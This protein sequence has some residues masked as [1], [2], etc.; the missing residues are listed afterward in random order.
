MTQTSSS[1]TIL[2]PSSTSLRNQSHIGMNVTLHL[3]ALTFP[4]CALGKLGAFSIQFLEKKLCQFSMADHCL[5]P[6]AE[7]S[8]AN[9]H[10]EVVK[11]RVGEILTVGSNL[12]TLP[13]NQ[14]RVLWFP[15]LTAH[16]S[17]SSRLHVSSLGHSFSHCHFVVVQHSVLPF[18]CYPDSLTLRCFLL[19]IGISN[20][21]SLFQVWTTLFIY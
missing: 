9:S 10:H 12:N 8:L 15:V 3:R 14:S 1:L 11:S 7:L 16:P 21:L 19:W 20:A 4:W 17:D 5:V 6:I 13:W 2:H 18:I